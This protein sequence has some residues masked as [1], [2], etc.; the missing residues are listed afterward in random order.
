M[1]SNDTNVLK[2]KKKL[3]T[4]AVSLSAKEGLSRHSPVQNIASGEPQRSMGD[5][6]LPYHGPIS[7]E[8]ES[9][10]FDLVITSKVA[11]GDMVG[12]ERTWSI[13]VRLHV[14]ASHDRRL[15]CVTDREDIPKTND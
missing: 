1:F 4:S 5:I 3:T 15:A 7:V 10:F 9:D 11:E 2:G 12:D 13:D 6:V 14:I 8:M